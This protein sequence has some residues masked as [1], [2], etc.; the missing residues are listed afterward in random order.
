[1]NPNRLK[2]YY[3]YRCAA[4]GRSQYRGSSAKTCNLACL[5]FLKGKC[6]GPIYRIQGTKARTRLPRIQETT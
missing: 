3:E 6:G 5:R 4:C 2:V 1:M